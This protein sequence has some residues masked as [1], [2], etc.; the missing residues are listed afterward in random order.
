MSEISFFGIVLRFLLG[1]GAVAAAYIVS[2]FFGGRTGGIFAAFPAVYLAA[3]VSVGAG[4]AAPAGLHEV[5][6]VSRGAVVG[7]LANIF[8]A[9]AAAF[10]IPVMGWRQGLAASIAGWL[11][12]VSV[13]LVLAASM[14]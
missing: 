3:V 10:F 5:L 13:M 11:A 12:T 9:L 8:C 14:N 1:G 2:R 6:E 4:A 7:M